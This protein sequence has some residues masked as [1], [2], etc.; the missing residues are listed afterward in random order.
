[1]QF[2]IILRF[3]FRFLVC[4][5]TVT[6]HIP[7]CF[8]IMKRKKK[9][10]ISV[11]VKLMIIFFFLNLN[12]DNLIYFLL[13][14]GKEEQM[15]F[16]SELFIRASCSRLRSFV[17]HVM[18]DVK[19]DAQEKLFVLTT[20]SRFI[21]LSSVMQYMELLDKKLTR[22]GPEI[23]VHPGV[24]LLSFSFFFVWHFFC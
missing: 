12:E 10:Y 20:F 11:F 5:L 24:T 18:R 9:Q 2:I 1:M 7:C 6:P 3:A 16:E 19:L 8:W 21:G 17:H 4:A 15:T 23:L 22:T 14:N 13:T